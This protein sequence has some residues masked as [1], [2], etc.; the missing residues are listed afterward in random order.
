MR[1]LVTWAAVVAR[2]AETGNFKPD[3]IEGSNHHGANDH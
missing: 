3:E 2:G 1:G